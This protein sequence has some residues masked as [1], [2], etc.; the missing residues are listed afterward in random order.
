LPVDGKCHLG[1]DDIYH[2]KGHDY[3][4]IEELDDILEKVN[5]KAIFATPLIKQQSSY[6]MMKNLMKR[7]QPLVA[8]LANDSANIVSVLENAY[9]VLIR[10][11]VLNFLPTI[12]L[13]LFEIFI[14]LFFFE[15]RDI[16]CLVFPP[17][18]ISSLLGNCNE[19]Y[20]SG[21]EGS[22][23]SSAVRFTVQERYSQ[24]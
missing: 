18:F 9:K 1:T 20:N 12:R 2:E 19:S 8:Q 5:I 22:I 6:G 14:D 4:S 10:L 16:F 11:F 23:R 17:R 15:R 21:Q 13:I 7:S 24:H 3:P